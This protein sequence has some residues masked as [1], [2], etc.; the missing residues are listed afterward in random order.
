MRDVRDMGAVVVCAVGMKGADMRIE[1]MAAEKKGKRY[2]ML[3]A[4]GDYMIDGFSGHHLQCKCDCGR[5]VYVEYEKLINM[6]V[7]NCGCKARKIRSQSD[8]YRTWKGMRAKCEDKENSG[9]G[10]VGARGIRV[11]EAWKDFGTFVQ[12]MGQRPK[13]FVLCRMD[14]KGGYCKENCKWGRRRTSAKERKNAVMVEYNEVSWYLMDLCR[15]MNISVNAVRQR[16]RHGW[17]VERAVETP[18]HSSVVLSDR[19]HLGAIEAMDILMARGEGHVDAAWRVL[20][21]VV[22]LDKMARYDAPCRCCAGRFYLAGQ[23]KPKNMNGKMKAEIRKCPI[24]NAG[25]DKP[26]VVFD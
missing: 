26:L 1:D 4:T 17:S 20:N 23:A 2:G 10:T 12:D 9:Y 6:T 15:D 5:L 13:G 18:I 7:T 11:C 25:G 19:V 8:M 16:L 3:V 21:K 24:C 22:N 14:I